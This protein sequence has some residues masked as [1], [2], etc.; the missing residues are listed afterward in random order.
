MK[1]KKLFVN[2][3]RNLEQTE[4]S[5]SDRFNIF[6][7]DN[8]QG[9]TNLLESIYLLGTMKSF[10]LAKNTELIRHDAPFGVLR[11]WVEKDGVTREISLLLEKQGKKVR[12]DQKSVVKLADFF[13]NL[14]VVVF[15]PEEMAM[16]KGMP[17]AR[18]R[19]LDRAIFS[20]NAEYLHLHHEYHLILKNR[21]SI[22]KHRESGDLEVWSEK[23]ADAG[24]RLVSRRF[25]YVKGIDP[26]LKEMYKAISGG[27]E[28]AAIRYVPHLTGGDG[29]SADWTAL[30]AEALRK[31]AAEERR[32]AMTLAGPHRDDVE[33]LLDGQ[34]L[35]RFGSQGQQRSFVLALKMAEIDFLEATFGNPPI[36]LLDDMTSELDRYR[37]RNMMEFLAR[38][39]MQVFISTTG[40]NTIT[41]HEGEPHRAFRIE[42]GRVFSD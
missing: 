7:G 41:L 29:T 14:N 25:A 10:R 24:G 30:L 28:E 18:R 38:K 12:V 9:K 1:L 23:L 4:L 36:L 16:A 11:A 17:D 19:Y 2:S 3:F 35:K 13:G 33:F 39:R 6:F 34:S 31:G 26:L 20:S 40:L 37:N 15:S 22:L 42:A 5:F 8:A 32:R 21:N 27:G